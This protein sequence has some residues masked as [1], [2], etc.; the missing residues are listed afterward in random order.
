PAPT[1]GQYAGAPVAPHASRPAAASAVRVLLLLRFGRR[2]GAGR[3]AEGDRRLPRALPPLPGRGAE[4]PGLGAHGPDPRARAGAAH[5]D[6]HSHRRLPRPPRSHRLGARDRPAPARLS[7]AQGGAELGGDSFDIAI[8]RAVRSGS[9]CRWSSSVSPPG[10]A[11]APARPAARS[12]R[13]L[14]GSCGTSRACPRSPAPL[15]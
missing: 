5:L 10:P 4:L 8:S 13:R 15:G 1:V 12:P 7:S 2:P 14:R 6:A 9:E 11:K 3:E